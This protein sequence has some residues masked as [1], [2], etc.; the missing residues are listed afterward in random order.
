MKLIILLL[1]F[2]LAGSIN[3]YSQHVEIPDK[4]FLKAL[5]ESDVD[6]NGDGLQ[7]Y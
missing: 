4:A 1:T 6:T 2:A 5:I 3:L 7:L